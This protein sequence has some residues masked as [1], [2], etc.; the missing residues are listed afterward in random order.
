[1]A[2]VVAVL[3]KLK[4]RIAS[5]LLSGLFRGAFYLLSLS[6]CIWDA[7]LIKMAYEHITD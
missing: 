7:K 3:M 4:K 2:A 1:M 5:F 6:N